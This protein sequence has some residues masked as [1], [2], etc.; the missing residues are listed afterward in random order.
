MILVIPEACPGIE[1][2]LRESVSIAESKII[3]TPKRR[4]LLKRQGAK[5]PRKSGE[6]LASLRLGVSILLRRKRREG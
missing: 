2:T 6:I 3:H 1:S 5:T 4:R